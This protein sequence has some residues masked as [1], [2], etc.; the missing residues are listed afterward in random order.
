MKSALGTKKSPQRWET[1]MI[2]TTVSYI[3][4]ALLL[5]YKNRYGNE[6]VSSE[7]EKFIKE[8]IAEARRKFASGSNLSLDLGIQIYSKLKNLQIET[9]F[10]DLSES[11][12][13]KFYDELNLNGDEKFFESF[14]A[15]KT[16]NQKLERE[17]ND[18]WRRK[19]EEKA[20]QMKISYKI[21]VENSICEFLEI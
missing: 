9:S 13:D 4:P 18:N 11:S 19:I 12:L 21:S 14:L 8:I 6:G 2:F 16:F 1:C 17:K 10:D 20:G 3:Q 15:I 7:T 5:M